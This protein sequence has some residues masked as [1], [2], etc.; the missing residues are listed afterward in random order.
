MLADMDAMPLRL[1]AGLVWPLPQVVTLP[2]AWLISGEKTNVA[3]SH[4]RAQ[5]GTGARPLG[6]RNG[7]FTTA[8]EWFWYRSN[9]GDFCGLKAA[10]R[11]LARSSNLRIRFL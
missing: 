2:A 8:M 5:E 10:L 9:F 3:A 11:S 1:G 7:E 4:N 6:C